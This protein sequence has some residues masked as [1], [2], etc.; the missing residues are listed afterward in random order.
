MSRNLLAR[1]IVAAIFGPAII[2]I[3]YQGGWWLFGMLLVFVS[4]GI[5]EFAHNEGFRLSSPVFWVVLLAA[6]AVYATLTGMPVPIISEFVAWAGG[7]FVDA[8]LLILT[9][10][11]LLS[12]MFFSI[13]KSSPAELF[14]RQS[15]LVWGIIYL[16]LT[17]PL[18]FRVGNGVN[19]LSG[20][21]S[22]LF[23]FGI[24]WLGDTAAMATGKN[25]GRHKLAP[26]LS[27]NKTIEGFV[28]GVTGAIVIGVIMYLW[29]FQDLGL[30]HTLTV[31]VGCSLFGQLGDLVESMWKRSLGIK[32]S[33]AII[34]GHGGVLD[35]FDSLVFAAPFMFAYFSLVV[36]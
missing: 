6:I 5:G 22:L 3:A 29:K 31:A 36:S 18:V 4:V 17:Y 32:D 25:L 7:S 15:R 8:A 10:F 30:V 16:G 33:S 11:F 28:G 19:G 14:T 27:P 12:G 9:A 26:T 20:G 21:D 34:P 13:G 1:I 24:L 2:W 35:R 23:L